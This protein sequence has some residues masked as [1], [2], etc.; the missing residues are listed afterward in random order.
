MGCAVQADN[1]AATVAIVVVAAQY[2]ETA[3][4]VCG[5]LFRSLL[6]NGTM[7]VRRAPRAAVSWVKVEVK[8]MTA[9]AKL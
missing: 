6:D 5:P 8:E 3:S 7:K 9:I 1:M 2:P 4:S